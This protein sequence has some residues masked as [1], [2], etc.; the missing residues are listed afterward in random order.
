MANTQERQER[1]T[2]M[3]LVGVFLTLLGAFALREREQKRVFTLD[4]RDL[5]LFGLATFRAGRMVAYDRVTEPIRDPVTET[6]PD[7][8]EAGENVVAEGAG[9]QKAIGELVSCPTCVGTWVAAGLVYGFR[10]A[11]G[12][13]RL[14]AAILAVSGLSEL[15]SAISEA[16]SWSGKVARKHSAT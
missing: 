9:M 4:P 3:T 5:A 12:P 14:F 16:L 13:T 6:V 10:L 1:I 15:F 7:E 8:Y 11:P 2:Y